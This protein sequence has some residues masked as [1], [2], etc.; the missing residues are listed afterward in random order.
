MLVACRLLADGALVALMLFVSAGTFGWTQAWVLLAVLATGYLS[1]PLL[2]G[3]DVFRWHVLPQPPL[4]LSGIGLVCFAV[5][6]M[7]KQ[8]GLR[9]NVFATSEL[10]LQPE[11]RVDDAGVYA[12]VRHPFYAADP[13]ILVGLALW[14]ASSLA[15]LAA[16]VP[17]LLMVLWQQ[18]EER[19]LQRAFPAYHAYAERVPYRLIPRV[20]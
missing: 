1:L 16:V 18:R 10:R 6:W 8:V 15:A 20:C 19:F 12:R 4:R 2:A 5:G 7:L 14:L 13:L 11:H 17:I 3:L 9:D